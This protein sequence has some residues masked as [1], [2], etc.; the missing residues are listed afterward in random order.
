MLIDRMIDFILVFGYDYRVDL[1]SI[2][3]K[4]F[5]QLRGQEGIDY[6]LLNMIFIVSFNKL[7]IFESCI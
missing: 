6:V 4:D 7:L 3:Y 5:M 1:D 2:L